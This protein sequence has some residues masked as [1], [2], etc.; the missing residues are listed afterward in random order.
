[1]LFIFIAFT[2]VGCNDTGKKGPDDAT[3]KLAASGGVDSTNPAGA[4]GTSAQ[5]SPA[6]QGEVAATV[7]S[8]KRFAYKAGIVE[9]QSMS[10]PGMVATFYF[11]EFGEKLATITDIRDSINGQPIT[12]RNVNVLRD[13]E[14][15]LYDPLKKV[16]MKNKVL[17]GTANYFPVF[18]SLSDSERQAI[19]YRKLDGRSID[20][21]AC[22]G[23]E[24]I[25]NGM[26]VSVWTW[27]G[28]PLRTELNYGNGQSHVM[29]ATSVKLDAPL[30]EKIFVVPADI[31]VKEVTT[32]TLE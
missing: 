23:H 12:I 30:P 18:A 22:E 31:T 13:G 8:G 10:I 20:G 16:G 28:V 4:Q 25:R 27:G 1:M 5:G 9:M 15:I 6:V 21:K 2:L 32:P 14:S 24:F 19:S 29:E 26:P 11:D 7:A 3:G 17:D